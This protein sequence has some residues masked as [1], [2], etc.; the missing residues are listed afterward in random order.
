MSDYKTD[1]SVKRRL[2]E[3]E[4]TREEIEAYINILAKER[5][6][7]ELRIIKLENQ[8][9]GFQSVT[10]KKYMDFWE[11]SR[12]V[13]STAIKKGD[14]K[15]N[16][17]GTFNLLLSPYGGTFQSEPDID[18]IYKDIRLYRGLYS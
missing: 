10:R 4:Q 11:I 1:P 14:V 17:D 16:D 3:L 7:S 12:R 15:I 2:G 18:T 8:L 6:R 5:L 9:I 13:L